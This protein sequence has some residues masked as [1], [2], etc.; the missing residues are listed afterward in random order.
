MKYPSAVFAITLL[1]FS[2]ALP[3]QALDLIETPSLR[4]MVES[5]ELPPVNER[6][7]AQPQIPSIIDANKIFSTND[8]LKFCN[9]VTI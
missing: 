2:M 1:G 5:A 8:C 7:P 9:E 4:V 3:V 6:I